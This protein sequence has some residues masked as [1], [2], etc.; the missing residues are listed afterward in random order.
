MNHKSWIVIALA[1]ATL[2]AAHAQPKTQ[3][4]FRC[5]PDGRVYS[6]TPCMDGTAVDVADPRSAEAQRA[7]AQ[8]TQRQQ[9]QNEKDARERKAGEAAAARQGAAHIPYTAAIKAAAPASAAPSAAKG[10]KK[11]KPPQG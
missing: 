1:A 4:V 7:A 6:Q 3:K 8:A 10:R 2:A 5:G 9:A 11:P